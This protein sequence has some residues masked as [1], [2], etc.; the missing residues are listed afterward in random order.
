MDRAI[1]TTEDGSNTLYIPDLNE[2]YH[3]IHG[4]IQESIHV[5]IKAGIVHY[6]QKNIRILEAGFGTGL[7][8]FLTLMEARENQRNVVFHT[9]EKYPLTPDEVEQLNYPDHFAP[10]NASLFARLHN[11]PW[12]EDVVVTPYFTLHKHKADFEEVNFQAYF[13]IVFFDAFAPDVQ[14]RLWT[15]DMF[16]KFYK[17]LKPEGILTTYCV[18]GTVKR[19]LRNLGFKLK[20][21]PGPPGKREMLRGEKI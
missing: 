5:F 17:A 18:K 11:T 4:A 21:L 9:F 15:E 19:A 8:A 16:A 6:G 13:D 12:N 20:R 7:N 1:I 14:P 2:P 10:E 3:S